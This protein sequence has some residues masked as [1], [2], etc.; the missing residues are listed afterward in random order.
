M[1]KE[2]KTTYMY[3]K[4]I[5]V[6]NIRSFTS[7]VKWQKKSTSLILLPMLL[8]KPVYIFSSIH[9][10]KTLLFATPPLMLGVVDETVTV[11]DQNVSP[12]ERRRRNARARRAV[13]SPEQR[14]L[15]NKRRRDSYA[16]KRLFTT[17]EEK[18]E[19]TR[20]NNRDYKKRVK[21]DRANNLH[22][23]SIAMANPQFKPELIFPPGDEPPSRLSEQMEIPDFGGTPVFVDA[24][25]PEPLHQVETP[26]TFLSNTIHTSHL[27]PGLRCSRRKH[28]NQEFEGAVGRNTKGTTGEN[29]NFASQP[30]QSCVVNNGKLLGNLY[31]YLL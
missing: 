26:D 5:V 23:D 17:P 11:D 22:P 9:W 18:V 3:W 7:S 27:T 31:I 29:N 13:L 8:Q 24:V 19:R 12:G 4:K 25:V 20:K 30:T 1:N 21:E 2:Q 6:I 15:I 28:R 14:A 16:A 10:K